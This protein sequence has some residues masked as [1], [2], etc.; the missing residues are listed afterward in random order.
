[1]NNPV[2]LA[3]DVAD[4]VQARQIVEEVGD[5]IGGVKIGATLACAL[6]VS[7]YPVSYV[8]DG[9]DWF[10]DLK[11]NDIPVQ[12]AGAIPAI[13]AANP[14]LISLHE[15]GGVE[16]MRA[17]VL[18]LGRA[19]IRPKLLAVTRLTSLMATPTQIVA[20]AHRAMTCGLDGV[21][22]SPQEL[23]ILRSELGTRPILLTPGIRL[24]DSPPDD[25]RR[26]A[27][28]KEA[29][30]AGANYIVVGRPIINAGNRREAA[31]MI[32]DSLG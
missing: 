18:S 14:T 10:L 29:I 13:M 19:M 8:V 31:R 22:A 26:T 11:F 27:T 7:T 28:P 25:Q 6:L 23:R 17:A 9:F 2:Y 1:M 5:L 12:T 21:I 3:L 24:P 32:L 15:D 4:V 20:Q 16:M 30:D